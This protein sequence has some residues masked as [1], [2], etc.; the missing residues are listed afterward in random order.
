MA[1]PIGIIPTI[2]GRLYQLGWTRQ[3][4]RVQ[5]FLKAASDRH[6]EN[7]TLDTTPYK[8]LVKLDEFLKLYWQCDQVL[9]KL[10]LGWDS[11]IVGELAND[12][13][14]VNKMPILGWRHLYE[15][16]EH[17]YFL[18]DMPTPNEPKAKK[19]KKKISPAAKS[20]I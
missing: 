10:Q 12:Y 5:A 3:H 1:N 13:G 15:S 2:D 20:K 4:P 6:G 19:E 8:Y 7:L 16:L 17:Q 9:K 18:M 14:G 11:P